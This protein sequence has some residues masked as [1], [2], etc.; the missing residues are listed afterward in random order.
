MT[1]DGSD[2]AGDSKYIWKKKQ[3][4]FAKWDEKYEIKREVTDDSRV[5]GPSN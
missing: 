5:S 1:Q 2:S 4:G 3:A